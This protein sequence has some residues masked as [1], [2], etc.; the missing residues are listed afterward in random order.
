MFLGDPSS[1]L[2]AALRTQQ[3]VGT[4]PKGPSTLKTVLEHARPTYLAS[5]RGYDLRKW[6][7]F[8]ETTST[9]HPLA[10]QTR[11]KYIA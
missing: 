1:T 5:C 11:Q 7:V 6:K 4:L 10:L 2:S 8:A 3:K 9:P